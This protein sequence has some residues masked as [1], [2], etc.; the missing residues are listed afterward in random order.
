LEEEIIRGRKEARSAL[1][2]AVA[3]LSKNLED[4]LHRVEAHMAQESAA[5]KEELLGEREERCTA[6]SVASAGIEGVRS[7]LVQEAEVRT[8][9]FK[10]TED[11]FIA[12]K[13]TLQH[14]K[15]ERLEMQDKTDMR[16]IELGNR[17]VEEQGLREQDILSVRDSM[18][19]VVAAQQREAQKCTEG[20]ENASKLIQEV[21]AAIEV[22]LVEH[23]E[24]MENRLAE[25]AK[26]EGKFIVAMDKEKHVSEM[27]LLTFARRI[28]DMEQ[29]V[30]QNSDSRKELEDVLHQRIDELVEQDEK[31]G[32]KWEENFAEH[33][34]KH[35]VLGDLI[36]AEAQNRSHE[37]EEARA[38]CKSLEEVLEKRLEG[39][40]KKRESNRAEQ[41]KM[42]E[43]IMEHIRRD[44]ANYAEEQRS[45]VNLLLQHRCEEIRT[46]SEAFLIEARARGE[47]LGREAAERT[48]GEIMVEV[49]R[50]E[51]TTAELLRA[52]NLDRKESTA[53]QEEQ[54]QKA[55]V[56][57]NECLTSHSEFM[58]ALASEQQIL[59]NR[60]NDGLASEDIKL[61]TLHARFSS[62]ESDMQKVRG[63]L[64]ILFIP[65]SFR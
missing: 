44:H 11:E 57:V 45:W 12:M 34:T 8:S 18:K 56:K 41:S 30:K 46:A 61:E 33:R 42:R 36:E 27:E 26:I 24:T 14:E 10:A 1:D 35:G 15:T 6:I 32:R 2:A 22:K 47:E 39:E 58:E 48:R 37:L 62:L 3:E 59:I 49:R 60:L 17:L 13:A 20:F 19:E 25:L 52:Q 64:P 54:A 50:I 43:D 9:S 55:A 4:A 29:R 53:R 7:L 31:D 40:G 23:K 65:C 16:S 51:S 28:E 63:H 38:L 21:A 5:M